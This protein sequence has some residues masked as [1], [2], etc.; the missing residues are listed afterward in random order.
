[1]KILRYFGDYAPT[2]CVK[3]YD[4]NRG[5]REVGGRRRKR[6]REESNASID[7]NVITGSIVGKYGI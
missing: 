5:K 4:K 1:M 2:L 3:K 7:H 6:R